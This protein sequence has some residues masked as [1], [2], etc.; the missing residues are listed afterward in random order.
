MNPSC[1]I[2]IRAFN[3]EKH[4]GRL[5][6]GISR[7]SIKDVQVI[8]VD[9][10]STDN[11][12][13]IAEE[14]K[15]DIVKIDPQNFTFGRSL[16]LGIQEARSEIILIASAHVFP[17]YP[18]WI[19]KMIAPFSDPSVA[20]VYGKQRGIES[21]RFTE[22]QIFNHWFPDKSQ[23][24]QDH[25]FCNNANSAIRRSL[26]KI[27]KY[28]ESLPGLEDLAWAK[29]AQDNKYKIIYIAQAEIKHVHE[30]SIKGVKKRYLREGMAFKS[31]YPH[32]HFSIQDLFRL[33]AKN[34][35]SD[36]SQAWKENVLLKEFFGIIKFRWFQFSGT[37]LGYRRSG[38][39]TWQLK[40]SFYYPRNGN[41]HHT[42][43]IQRDVQPIDYQNKS[44]T[45][46]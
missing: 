2:V 37:Y 11:T 8:L 30:E 42:H 25:P 7:Q 33:F 18:D 41:S 44:D 36:I 40:Q 6:E 1:S 12:I 23:T 46:E 32:E 15:V 14:K 31:I 17:V 27:N 28:D 39:L 34:T 35:V 22:K 4:L 3:E 16:N 20:L 43:Q 10:G 19:E 13:N 38:P 29:W 5:L 24:P 26:W 21:S 9:S 45:I